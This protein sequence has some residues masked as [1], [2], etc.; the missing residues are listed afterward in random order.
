MSTALSG[1]TSTFAWPPYA[2]MA[3]RTVIV[4][5]LAYLATRLGKRLI[6]RLESM[7]EAKTGPVAARRG[8]TVRGLLNSVL[9]FTILAA[10]ILMVLDLMGLD[11]RSLLAGA[12]IIGLVIGFGAQSLIRD[13]FSGFFIIYD[14]QFNVGD[15]VT[16]GGLNGVIEEM[17]LSVAKIRDFN[18]DLHYVRYGAIDKVTNHSRGPIRAR[19]DVQVSFDEAPERVK[20]ALLEACESAAS[21]C[22]G[23]REK[24][25]VL[26]ITSLEGRR[27]VYTVT[28]M[29]EPGRQWAL[30]R[31]IRRAALEAFQR[32]GIRAPELM[33][34]QDSNSRR[35][36]RIG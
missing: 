7:Q 18:G 8:R 23:V 17:G 4:I 2:E 12:G 34:C 35:G 14:D 19:V 27:V 29:T 36:E 30:E 16:T 33:P 20:A 6:D 24:P 11:T 9:R 3:V 31:E 5:T 32:A 15:F 13:L 21:M 28:G 10:A 26:G 25:S 1:V 22:E